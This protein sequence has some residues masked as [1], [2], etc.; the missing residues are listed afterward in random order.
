MTTCASCSAQFGYK[1]SDYKCMHC[2]ER[3]CSSH[4]VPTEF[5]KIDGRLSAAFAGGGAGMCTQCILVVW[6]KSDAHLEAP[7]TLSD[8]AR[9]GFDTAWRAVWST[10]GRAPS[11]TEL[12]QLDQHAFEHLNTSLAFGILRRHSDVEQ[13]TLVA[14]LTVFARLYAVSQGRSGERSICLKDVYALVDWLRT[15]PQMPDWAQEIRWSMLESS[16]GYLSYF[17]DVFRMAQIALAAT[18]A[19]AAAKAGYVVADEVVTRS[20]G[21]GLLSNFYSYSKDSLGIN[22]NLRSALISYFAGEFI[23]QLLM[24][25]AKASAA[26]TARVTAPA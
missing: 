22:V 18:P 14:E 12:L 21:K 2:Q 7:K 9:V 10:I 17:T 23:M 16:P 15:H 19:G 4:L 8:R 3:F 26:G 13:S 1:F 5:L 24:D 6:E 11:G 20:T 25:R